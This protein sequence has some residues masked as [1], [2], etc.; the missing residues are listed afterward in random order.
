MRAR[1]LFIG[2]I[3]VLFVSG[4]GRVLAATLCPHMAQDHS[5]CHA[6]MAGSG[7]HEAM[8]DMQMMP[9]APSPEPGTGTLGQP[10]EACAHCIGHS[11]IP[12]TPVAA[13]EANQAKRIPDVDAPLALMPLALSAPSFI[14]AIS[15]RQGSPPGVTGSRHV[16]ISIF[17]I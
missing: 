15:S 10:V 6:L 8:G 5:C 13:H 14:L 1:S 12:A 17:R 4:W 3:F 11:G 7:S 2:I 9:A 16:L